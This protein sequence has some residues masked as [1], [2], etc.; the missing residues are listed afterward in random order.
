MPALIDP[1][2]FPPTWG[3]SVSRIY[4]V[5]SVLHSVWRNVLLHVFGIVKAFV[6][7][8]GNFKL[9]RLILTLILLGIL[10]LCII[11][12]L[13]PTNLTSRLSWRC[14]DAIVPKQKYVFPNCSYFS[15]WVYRPGQWHLLFRPKNPLTYFWVDICKEV[16][17]RK[18]QLKWI[19]LWTGVMNL[20]LFPIESCFWIFFEL[21][22][23]IYGNVW[24]EWFFFVRYVNYIL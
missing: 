4:W 20:L 21:A 1:S 18:G 11:L 23:E 19:W 24:K 3:I 6:W 9:G 14:P 10:T 16:G 13:I 17:D 22:N 8:R 12:V 15:T 2:L 7:L 5:S